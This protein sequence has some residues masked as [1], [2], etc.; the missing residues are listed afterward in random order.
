MASVSG[1]GARYIVT[2]SGISGSGTLGLAVLDD[3]A[4][5]DRL[6]AA[7]AGAA[8]GAVNQQ[9]TIDRQL[10]WSAAN[11]SGSWDTGCHWRVGG[12]T[13]P[14]QPWCDGSDVVFAGSPGNVT[15]VN[16][17]VVASLTFLSDGYVIEGGMM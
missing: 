2:V 16:P 14:L 3:G 10:Y 11:G 9:Y 7:L 4:I 5:T 13:G 6:G 17:V 12:P 15:V 1:A 8:T